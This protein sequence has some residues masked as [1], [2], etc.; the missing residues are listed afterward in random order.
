MGY[1]YYNLTNAGTLQNMA[2][3]A[4]MGGGFGVAALPPGMAGVAGMYIIINSH[5]AMENR[6]VGISQDIGHRFSSRMSVVTELGFSNAVMGQINVV[7]GTVKIRNHPH[8]LP[9]AQAPN[10]A[11][12]YGGGNVTFPNWGAPG[13]TTAVPGGGGAFTRIVDGNTINLEKLLIRFVMM[14]L[15]AGGTVSNNMLMTPFDHPN[16]LGA[17]GAHPLVVKFHSAPFGNYNGFTGVDVLNPGFQ[18]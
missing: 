2:P 12:L 5:G 15:G 9:L 1:I 8:G 3:V 18:W 16:G 6:Y 13:W 17:F 4:L 14:R 7:W 10:N 11:L